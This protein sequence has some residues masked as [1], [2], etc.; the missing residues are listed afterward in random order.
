[1]GRSPLGREEEEGALSLGWN[2]VPLDGKRSGGCP[3]VREWTASFPAL[4]GSR[5][6]PSLPC[7]GVDGAFPC[8]V[9]E[10]AA[11]FS[12][13]LWSGGCPLVREWMAPFPA[14]CGN[15]RPPSLPCAGV[16]GL[17]PCLVREW[18]ASFPALLWSGGRPLVREWMAPFPALC[19]NVRPP[20]LPCYGVADALW[21]GSGR[22]LS[23]PYAGM[24][25]LLL[26]LVMEWRMPSGAGV[27]GVPPCLVT[28]WSKPGGMPSWNLFRVAVGAQRSFSTRG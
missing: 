12:A 25:G 26:C 22:R 24:C 15:V 21:C 27:D 16:D 2:G 3:L 18:T 1:M 7:A 23:L 17:L 13:L 20:S 9:R 5:R 14:L 6:P 19:G 4:C 8:L 28:K 10:C 11:S